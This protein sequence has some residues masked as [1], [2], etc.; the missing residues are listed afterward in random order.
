MSQERLP[1]QALLAKANGRRSVGGP[2][3]R[4]T[5]Y[6]KDRG[7]NRSGLHTSEMMNVMEDREVVR[8][9]L[10]LQHRFVFLIYL[11]TLCEFQTRFHY[12]CKFAFESHDSFLKASI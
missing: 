7:W 2:R 8:L 4:W 6:I 9:N 10:D 11:F 1:K 5:N 3:T 12:F